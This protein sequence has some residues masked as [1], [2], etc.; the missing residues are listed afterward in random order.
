M[1]TEL[2]TISTEYGTVAYRI[3]DGGSG[4]AVLFIHGAVGDSRLFRHQL[5]FFGKKYRALAVDLPGHGRSDVTATPDIGHFA[6]SVERV[7]AGEDIG[8][9]VLAGHSM[10]GGICFELYRRGNLDIRG[11]VL[12]STAPRLPVPDAMYRIAHED[13]PAG[14]SD[15]LIGSVFSKKTQLL[16][17]VARRGMADFNMSMVRNDMKICNGMDYTGLLGSISVPV[18]II[19]AAGDRVIAAEKT[20]SMGER[21]PASKVVVLESEGHVPFFEYDDEF[22]AAVDSFLHELPQAV[23][24][25]ART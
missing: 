1:R 25:G 14:F 4:P 24:C 2:R 20:A 3:A 7:C 19:A 8:P 6:D 22:N 10:G 23:A 11:I 21:I 16:V 15:V 9:V 12:V 17:E 13:N 18:L 5:R